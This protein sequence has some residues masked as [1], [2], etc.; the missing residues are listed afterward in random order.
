MTSSTFRECSNVHFVHR[1]KGCILECVFENNGR[2]ERPGG[3]FL[4][5]V[6][7]NEI[8]LYFLI[9]ILQDEA[10]VT[11]LTCEFIGNVAAQGGSISC[12]DNSII[13]ISECAFRNNKAFH[14]LYGDGGAILL[15]VINLKITY[16]NL[17]C[18]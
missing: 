4:I 18:K 15:T 11:F 1:S 2:K 5:K 8:R 7:K 3:A 17:N 16:L 9:L 12:I 6:F 13:S 14:P 10:D